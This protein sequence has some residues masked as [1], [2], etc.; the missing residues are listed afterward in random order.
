MADGP[1]FFIVRQRHPVPLTCLSE[2]ATVYVQAQTT[3]V[4][5][6]SLINNPQVR[7]HFSSPLLQYAM[8][9]REKTFIH[10]ECPSMRPVR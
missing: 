9:D 1:V 8:D 4:L 10:V 2:S 3:S 7:E 6:L 5:S